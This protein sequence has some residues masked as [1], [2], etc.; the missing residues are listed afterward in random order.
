MVIAFA[1]VDT[2]FA[3]EQKDAPAH[4][5]TA[6]KKAAAKK[7]ADE[8]TSAKKAAAHKAAAKPSHK[9]EAKKAE[10]K[11]AETKKADAK[12]KADPKKE[13]AKRAS[14]PAKS[15]ADSTPP[16]PPLPPHLVAVKQAIALVKRGSIE[17]AGKLAKSDSDPAAQKLIEWVI[18]RNADSAPGFDRYA[19][20]IKD[21]PDWPSI[22]LL[23][24]RA[25]A[26]LWLKPRDAATMR[27]FIGAQPASSY[28]K[29]VLARLR[30]AEGD[31]AGAEREVRAV[32]RSAELSGE[33]EA[34]IARDFHAALT[35]ADNVARMDRRIGAKEFGAAMRA[36]KLVGSAQMEIV[37]ACEASEGNS[38]KAADLL[39][40]VPGEVRSDLGYQLCRLHWLVARNDL[41]AAARVFA[42]ASHDDLQRQDTDEWWR[43]GRLLARKLLD[44][45]D[46][47]MAYRV[48]QQAPVPANPYYR[49]EYHFMAGWIAL[50]F[51]DDAN[52]AFQHFTHVDEGTNDPIVLAR[53]AYWRGRAAEAAGRV[54]EMQTQYQAAAKYPTAYYGQLARARLSIVDLAADIPAPSVDGAHGEILHAADIL[55]AIGEIDLGRTFV[56]D[57]ARSGTDAA[58]L[59]G[60]GQLTARYNDAQTMLE[61][62]KTSLARGLATARYAFPTIGIPA[63]TPIAPSIDP[64]MAFSIVRTESGFDPHDSSPAK[65]VGLMQV[66]PEAARDTARRFK[67]TYDW[68]RLVNDSVYNMQM[69]AAELSALFKEYAGS[70]VMTFAG[71]NAGRGRV[72]QWVAEHGDPRDPR[73]DAVDW[74]ERIPLAETRN[75]VQRVMENI[76][77]YGALLGAKVKTAE[78]NLHRPATLEMPVKPASLVQSDPPPTE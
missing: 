11:K 28:G 17:E 44:A 55:Y 56:A 52:A 34:A 14:E 70:Y 53:G 35:S 47:R 65:A 21:N 8:K 13:E 72:R 71:Y 78:P 20:F 67:A 27:A 73:I 39:A 22:P 45:R 3:G 50:R 48:V 77:V 60:L 74:V 15:A 32:W 64:C 33:A 1:A 63:Y 23:R 58:T 46:A 31:R 75:Y 61:M 37:K 12:K 49:A 18:L 7:T 9:A 29:L 10:T 40:S 16:P 42:D 59:N 76:Q 51:L 19:T 25:E 68:K 6:A 69:G 38:S 41:A 5:K 30:Q 2:S 26:T 36:A 62:G 66:T 54:E 4:H 57:L 43:E 24:R